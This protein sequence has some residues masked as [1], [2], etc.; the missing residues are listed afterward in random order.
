MNE[1]DLNKERKLK[2]LREIYKYD[3]A[4]AKQ[5]GHSFETKQAELE[6]LAGLHLSRQIQTHIEEFAGTV[7]FD[8][9]P[10]LILMGVVC[11]EAL[12]KIAGQLDGE[13]GSD[14]VD[15]ALLMIDEQR[16]KFR[17]DTGPK[18]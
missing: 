5:A 17:K 16:A 4:L 12:G 15:K 18:K 3:K 8:S 10:H 13:I 9:L 7:G 11:N 6:V 14:L 1:F 2:E